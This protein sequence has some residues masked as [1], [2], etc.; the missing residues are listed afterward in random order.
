[1]TSSRS[2]V[3]LP[4]PGGA[5]ASPRRTPSRSLRVK[6][7]FTK[8]G[9]HPFDGISWGERRLE[10]R[11]GKGKSL[12]EGGLEFPESWSQ[13]AANIAGSKYFRGRIG[14][15]EKEKSVKQ[16]I[17]R[18]AGTIRKWGEDFGYFSVLSDAESFE[19]EL[20]HLLINQKAA[21]N[22]PVWF[23]VGVTEKPQCSACFILKVDDNMPSILDWIKNE[24][25]IFKGG[26]GAGINLSP[27]R[28][29]RE[30]MSKGGFASGPV[31]FMRGADSVAGMIKSGGS[32][33]RA[34]KMV[35]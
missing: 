12:D 18:V 3:S 11:V 5:V 26:S 25:M 24:G 17:S 14:S 21:F 23:N 9:E 32:T 29:S 4:V 27:L 16:M 28:S 19:S 1:M 35:V 10:I 6:R 20:T 33:R 30:T 22:S 34:A 13:N 2:S 15:P 31:S 7:M 8:I